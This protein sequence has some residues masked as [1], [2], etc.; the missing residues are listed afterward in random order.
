MFTTLSITSLSQ[1][2]LNPA[3]HVALSS[4][5]ADIAQAVADAAEQPKR[6]TSSR[7]IVW[8]KQT[9]QL[10]GKT[11]AGNPSLSAANQAH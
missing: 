2:S 4:F 10:L 1:G 7:I 3:H 9:M 6:E 5:D 8:I 11:M